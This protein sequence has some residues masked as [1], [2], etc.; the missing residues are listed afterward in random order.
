L[1]YRILVVRVVAIRRI[2]FGLLAHAIDDLR[3]ALPAGAELS[4]V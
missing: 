1:A 4:S 2:D 3:Q